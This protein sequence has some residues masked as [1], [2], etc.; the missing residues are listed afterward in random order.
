MVL[1]GEFQS[2]IEGHTLECTVDSTIIAARFSFS[3]RRGFDLLPLV[4]CVKPD[5]LVAEAYSSARI[6]VS[7]EYHDWDRFLD[8]LEGLVKSGMLKPALSLKRGLRTVAKRKNH[9]LSEAQQGRLL[10]LLV[11]SS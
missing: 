2:V 7:M 8:D 5:R 9:P 4:R 3:G 10:A 11:K 6:V 1:V